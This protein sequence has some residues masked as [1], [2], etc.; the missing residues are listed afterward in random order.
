[1][2]NNPR[3]IANPQILSPGG[4]GLSP[5]RRVVPAGL[6]V[7]AQGLEQRKLD[8]ASFP[9]AASASGA[10]EGDV[11]VFRASTG[12]WTNQNWLPAPFGIG[13]PAVS[14]RQLTVQSTDPT[15]Y[16]LVVKGADAQTQQLL[17]FRQ[18]NDDLILSV[19]ASG[20]VA[21]GTLPQKDQT[22]AVSGGAYCVY[23]SSKAR[24][25]SGATGL[26]LRKRGSYALPTTLEFEVFIPASGAV[27][28]WGLGQDFDTSD[29]DPYADFIPVYDYTADKGAG[30]DI[31]R[32]SAAITNPWGVTLWTLTNRS[33][34]ARNFNDLLTMRPGAFGLGGLNIGVSGGAALTLILDQ[35]ATTYDR[36]Q[37]AL[38]AGYGSLNGPNNRS[39][40][41]QQLV[42]AT[43]VRNYLFMSGCASG[44]TTASPQVFSSFGKVFGF[45]SQD[46][47]MAWITATN[48]S[49]QTPTRSLTLYADGSL[50]TSG[51]LTVAQILYTSRCGPIVANSLQVTGATQLQALGCQGLAAAAA[52]LN[53]LTVTGATSLNGT[54]LVQG[55]TNL[56]G[57]TA[58]TTQVNTLL[59][60]GAAQIQGLTNLGTTT[61]PGL[62]AN[63]ALV[64]G[65]IQVNGATNLGATTLPTLAANSAIIT[66][67][68]QIMGNA[69]LGNLVAGI[70]TLSTLTVTGT[71]GLATLTTTSTA[72]FAGQVGGNGTA[73]TWA[74]LS[75]TLPDASDY[76]LSAAEKS[77][78]IVD[79]QNT[80]GAS[81]ATNIIV[82]GNAGAMY[83]VINRTSFAMTLKVSGQTGIAVASQ[84][85][86]AI[87]WPGG[88][89]GFRLS[90]D[91]AYTS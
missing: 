14:T 34:T 26:I 46:G 1:M 63:S 87:L 56:Q 18:H 75:L 65:A 32:C 44:G 30:A 48:G 38:T 23:T 13:V 5:L 67:A 79:I 24:P 2:A 6:T 73:F 91:T 55:A 4:L 40:N 82:P 83:L 29:T 58:A 77:N 89:V 3:R 21:I 90:P 22:F 74:R 17:Q 33:G 84:R 39:I 28:T 88:T 69:T 57:L 78:V 9:L 16:A 27:Q 72:K 41:L 54:L 60:T 49:P 59:V 7:I 20:Q 19:N 35:T 11:L 47:Q 68:I 81:G 66:G 10:V 62:T 52:T 25:K 15:R 51:N 70:T 36:T 71:T 50:A 31:L 80:A 43:E 61:L 85:A 42:S 37:T 86:A 8:I 53:S 12:L 45:E 64:T 76:T